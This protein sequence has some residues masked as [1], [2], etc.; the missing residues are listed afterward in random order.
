MDPIQRTLT[1]LALANAPGS[2]GRLLQQ[3]REIERAAEALIDAG[4]IR[5]FSCSEVPECG[6]TI[7][8]QLVSTVSQHRPVPGGMLYAVATGW[9]QL[10]V[11]QRGSL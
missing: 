8:A 1:A 2:A 11:S 7:T 9:V 6:D 5:S 4:F 3:T 10:E